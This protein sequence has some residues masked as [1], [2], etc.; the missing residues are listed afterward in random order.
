[1]TDINYFLS[2]KKIFISKLII[3][4]FRNHIDTNLDLSNG[5]SIF[6]GKN[7][8]GKSNLIEAI[9]MLAIAKSTRTS[10]EI[11]LINN[12]ISKKNGHVQI[13]AIGKSDTKNIQAQIDFDVTTGKTNPDKS[14]ILRKS[15]RVNGLVRKSPDFVGSINVVCFEVNNLEILTGP[16]SNRRKYI[17]I[18][19]SQTDQDYIRTLQRYRNVIKQRNYLL[20]L[21]KEKKSSEKELSFWDERLIYEGANIF[22]SR[23]R[24][25]QKLIEFLVPQHAILSGGD[26][27][28]IIYRPK[29]STKQQNIN[30]LT[31]E[32]IESL[33]MENLR[34][35]KSLEII[36]G[37]SLLGPH[38]DDIEIKFNGELASSRASRGQSRIIVLSLKLSEASILK[39]LTGYSPILALDDILSELD[40]EKRKI[41]LE[42]TINYE[43]VFITSS[44]EFIFKNI[45]L[46]KSKM[47]NIYEGKVTEKN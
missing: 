39:E 38:R 33:M 32:E 8:Q 10:Y 28:E 20:K 14:L 45:N 9:Y 19:I 23:K 30:N 46:P 3:S 41:V 18:L 26:E 2:E 16:P 43:Q 22:L 7:G 12:E 29:I 24:I 4:G 36:Q 6:I 1:M 34:K 17:D 15:L 37:I 5:I 25:I 40:E 47:Y 13:S 31:R 42:T 44:D 35:I 21:I 27:I 11:E